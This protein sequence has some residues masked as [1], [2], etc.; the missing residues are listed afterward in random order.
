MKTTRILLVLALAAIVFS[1][2]RD[3]D[4]LQPEQD[5]NFQLETKSTSLDATSSDDPFVQT[6]F[7]N[8]SA[9][10]MAELETHM[11]L[12]GYIVARVLMYKD[13]GP[14]RLQFAAAF[15]GGDTASMSTL[16]GNGANGTPFKTAFIEYLSHYFDGSP[17]LDCPGGEDDEPPLTGGNGLIQNTQDLVQDV[18]DFVTI[19]N[20]VELF[21]PTGMDYSKDQMTSVA[22]PMTNSSW[23]E[24]Y[25]RYAEPN[26]NNKISKRVSPVN[27]QYV[28]QN[29]NMIIVRPF[30]VIMSADC[31]YSQYA[32]IDFTQFLNN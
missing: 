24:G 16:I 13:Q 29:D 25:E 19:D 7:T 21:V 27:Q 28:N 3:N 9:P 6:D 18:I 17:C 30:K 23:N 31:H 14:E 11:Q 1:C 15:S 8:K 32:H 20:C 22:H 10:Q 12:T 26:E 4:I 2:S 5:V